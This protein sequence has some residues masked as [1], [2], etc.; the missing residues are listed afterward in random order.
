[1][2]IPIVTKD[3]DNKDDD[4]KNRTNNHIG[5]LHDKVGRGKKEPLPPKNKT[6]MNRTQTISQS[7]KKK[8]YL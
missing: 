6:A 4:N 3:G 1:M 5:R 2:V 7:S 8:C